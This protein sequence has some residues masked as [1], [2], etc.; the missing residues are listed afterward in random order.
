MNE[1]A[2]WDFLVLIQRKRPLVGL[3]IGDLL[4]GVDKRG[5]GAVF[6]PV[7]GLRRS[8][9]VTSVIA[10][11]VLRREETSEEGNDV[12]GN[13]YDQTDHCQSVLAEFPPHQLPLGSDDDAG[14]ILS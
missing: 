5:E 4:V 2:E 11:R 13:H 1:K 7:D 3:R 12:E 6:K 10:G 9:R 8:L 14:C